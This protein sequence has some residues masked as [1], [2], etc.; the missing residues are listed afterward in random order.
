MSLQN[1]PAQR[2]VA[3]LF[4]KALQEYFEIAVVALV[5]LFEHRVH[6]ALFKLAG[7]GVVRRNH[8]EI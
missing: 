6:S 8:F 3:T 2:P 7:D 5:K 4:H 1:E